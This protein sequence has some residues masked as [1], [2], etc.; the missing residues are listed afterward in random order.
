MRSGFNL[1]W[2][3][4]SF[5]SHIKNT[6]HKYFLFER[7]FDLNL[8]WNFNSRVRI[9]TSR[10]ISYAPL[11]SFILFHIVIECDAEVS[12][13][14]QC[15]LMSRGSV[16]RS[17]WHAHFWASVW[18]RPTLLCREQASVLTPR[19]G[20]TL[21]DTC[22]LCAWQDSLLRKLNEKWQRWLETRTHKLTFKRHTQ[23]SAK[24]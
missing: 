13:S 15:A 2:N 22:S 1:T 18:V 24:L 23:I 7:K 12:P 9:P 19:I 8:T 4:S 11:P 20:L 17:E 3:K 10:N 21:M 16:P 6:D 14:S 5:Q